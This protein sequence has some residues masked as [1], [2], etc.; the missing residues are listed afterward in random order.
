MNSVPLSR[1][2]LRAAMRGDLLIDLRN[3]YEP[4][5]MRSAGFTY[6]SIGRP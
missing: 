6:F 2:V 4:A 1:S 3:L 5:S